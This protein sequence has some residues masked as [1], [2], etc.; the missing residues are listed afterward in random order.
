MTLSDLETAPN[1][2]LPDE[3]VVVAGDWHANRP[4]IGRAIPAAA[5]TGVQTILHLGDFGFWPGGTADLLAAVEYWVGQSW[6]RR[7]TPGIERVLVTPGNHEDWAELDELFAAAPEQAARVSESVWVLPKGF[8]FTIAGREFLSFGGAA[9]IDYRYRTPF[10][11]WWPSEFPSQR[12]VEIA[13]AGGST[14][15]LL[16]H[17]AGRLRTPRVE[18]IISDPSPWT[19]AEREYTA[20]SRLLIDYV[21]AGTQPLL[22][23]H[24]H[25]HVRDSATIP[26]PGLPPLQVESLGMDDQPGNLGLLELA[27]LSVSDVEVRP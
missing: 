15:V 19:E 21:V 13:V 6:K 4:W 20:E 10:R 7:M 2:E 23:F 16:T 17:D 25:F 22:H 5:R 11:S 14:E 12:D 18:K 27:D 3:R 8:R 1:F 24:G 26:R 9:S